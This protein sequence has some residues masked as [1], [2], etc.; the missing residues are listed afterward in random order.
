MMGV[1]GKFDGPIPRFD[2]PMPSGA[3][4]IRS[5]PHQ[6]PALT[7]TARVAMASSFR[8]SSTITTHTFSELGLI[9]PLLRA[10]ASENYTE[11]TPIQIQAIPHLLGGRDLLGCAQTGSGKTA[12][13]A[14]P[15]LQ[16]LSATE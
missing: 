5:E 7:R 4:C 1:A 2:S 11:P 16:R 12:A 15:I 8:K 6:P 9:Q 10:V 3:P 13:F 14:L